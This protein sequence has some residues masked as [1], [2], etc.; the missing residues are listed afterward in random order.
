MML[1][2]IFI[3]GLVC[4]LS[5]TLAL[6]GKNARLREQR[7]KQREQAEQNSIGLQIEVK[8]V[9][10]EA[11]DS[12][13]LAGVLARFEYEKGRQTYLAIVQEYKGNKLIR[14][15]ACRIATKKHDTIAYVSFI[16]N[17]K[18]KN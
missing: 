8:S 5:L 15:S 1:R 11:A 18:F 4:F 12:A 3:I 13:Y 10:I 2:S 16:N 14:Q 7:R 6:P 9:P 17:E